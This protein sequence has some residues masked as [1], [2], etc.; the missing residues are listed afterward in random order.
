MDYNNIHLTLDNLSYALHCK[1]SEKVTF[2]LPHLTPNVVP[3][4]P[5]G[6]NKFTS[7]NEVTLKVFVATDSE[8]APTLDFV[9]EDENSKI[10]V[11][12][13]FELAV[14]SFI[15]ITITTIDGGLHW[16]VN[17]CNANAT[18]AEGALE[19]AQAAKKT[20]ETA[21]TNA[22]AAT[23]T[24]NNAKTTADGA[25]TV[26]TTAKSTA[27]TATQTA[28]SAAITAGTAISEATAA[29]S[30]ADQA[31]ATAGEAKTTADTAK[32][33]ADAAK[34]TAD[35]AKTTADSAQTTAETA[36]STADSAKSTADSA[37]AV[38]RAAETASGEAKTAAQTAVDTANG[39]VSTA[40]IAKETAETAKSDAAIAKS[41]AALA[42]TDAAAA[43]STANTANDTANEAKSTADAAS[44]AA[45]EA[46]SK[47][48]QANA[49]AE[50][51][52]TTADA[53]KAKAD[54]S[55]QLVTEPDTYQKLETGI[56][57]ANGRKFLL[58][59]RTGG[60]SLGM[61]SGCYEELVDDSTQA[62]LE[63]IEI[64]TPTKIMCL[65]HCGATFK[66]EG[67]TGESKVVDH[68]IRVDY[69]EK[70]GEPVVQDQLAYMSDITAIVAHIQKIEQ[71]MSID[72]A[73]L[74]DL[75][76]SKL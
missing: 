50:T 33:T 44:T 42:K 12:G 15:V 22:N 68:H 72:T 24:A 14:D 29:K 67:G 40:N 35:T 63:Q 53:A 36:K 55:L 17:S 3:N 52:Q 19:V 60:T 58:E 32:T 21:N 41:D 54:G 31:N 18:S 73:G 57:L 49:A 25:V 65:N 5:D 48:E 20:A 10:D 4:V 43:N 30:T 61:Y 70:A 62:G 76:V 7:A 75:P 69:R 71:Q 74:P 16:L 59:N 64:G 9:G 39:A 6:E 51:A 45:A 23:E 27:D 28:Q 8:S 26:A 11:V 1:S 13:N 38:A 2:Y 46:D 56:V 47:A 34:V 66:T 37:D